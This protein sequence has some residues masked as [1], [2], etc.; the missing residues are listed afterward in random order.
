MDVVKAKLSDLVSVTAAPPGSE[1]PPFSL[2][3]LNRENPGLARQFLWSSNPMPTEQGELWLHLGCGVRVFDGFVNMDICPQDL[4]AIKW[5]LLDLWPEDLTRRVEGVFS[6]DCLEHFFQ[7]EQAYILSNINWAMRLGGVARILMPSL[8]KVIA[9]AS[10]YRPTPDDYLHSNYGIETG[11]DAINHAMRF[12]GHRWLHDQQSLAH[13]AA[14]CG[15]HAVAT[16]CAGSG[17]PKLRGLNLRSE[18][19]SPSF[20]NDLHKTRHISR[21]LVA[22][23]RVE[24]ATRVED[25]MPDAA[26][27]V[28]TSERP[29][30]E[31]LLPHRVRSD[32]IA[33]MNF[34][35]S[36]L[37]AFDWNIKYLLIDGLDGAKLWSFDESLKS[38]PCMNII[39]ADQVKVLLGSVQELS[40]LHFKPAY[41]P[42]EYFTVGC[43][44]IFL[45]D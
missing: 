27:F 30:V 26:L 20:A 23:T 5:N 32:H 10:D 34:R 21:T 6:E 9:G 35:S 43:A 41:Q 29:V 42:G 4:R 15:F 28:A 45:L 12:T 14:A 24:G 2:A 44:E 16:D 17:I 25:S 37:S 19:N 39:S 40:R 36:N 1:R 3:R 33:C 8:A 18:G 11:A 31:Y 22:P 7:L 13:M 38:Q